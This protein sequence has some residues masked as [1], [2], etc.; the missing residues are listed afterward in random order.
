MESELK[1]A[2]TPVESVTITLDMEEA[3]ILHELV[4]SV[5]GTGPGR[6]VADK[7][8]NILSDIERDFSPE[9]FKWDYFEG[10]VKSLVVAKC[11]MEWPDV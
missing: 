5:Q 7:L 1:L 3:A 2:N 11:T 10:E 9:P 8:W 6:T 4:G